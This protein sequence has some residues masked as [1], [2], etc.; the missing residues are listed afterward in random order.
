LVQQ[1]GELLSWEDFETI[2]YTEG[3]F[4][5]AL[6]VSH[7]DKKRL[8]RKNSK[9]KLS[10]IKKQRAVFKDVFA[11]YWERHLIMRTQQAQ[12]AKEVTSKPF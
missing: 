5:D 3:T 10:G 12:A 6:I 7:P 1:S 4:S 8:G 2:N 11:R 9:I